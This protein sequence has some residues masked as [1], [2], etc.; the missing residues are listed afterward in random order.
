RE[1]S[2]Q[3]PERSA[4]RILVERDE[5]RRTGEDRFDD[6]WKAHFRDPK[7]RPIVKSGGRDSEICCPSKHAP[8][9]RAAC[10]GEDDVEC[11]GA[12]QSA[13]ARRRGGAR[14]DDVVDQE[15]A[16]AGDAR[17]PRKEAAARTAGPLSLAARAL[18]WAVE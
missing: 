9:S 13:R 12:T 18:R 11:A 17:A 1:A 8:G 2:H 14:R 4:A 5:L 3:R 16:A 6:G 7:D 10:R 15:H